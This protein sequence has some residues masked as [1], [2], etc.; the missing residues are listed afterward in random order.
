MRLDDLQESQN[1]VDRRSQSDISG[2]SN[3]DGTPDILDGKDEVTQGSDGEYY[4]GPDGIPDS[5]QGF[6]RPESLDEAA[7]HI[8][9]FQ[10]IKIKTI[11]QII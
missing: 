5:Q 1:V 3:L 9:T 7:C 4:W 8:E 2:D 11:F 10:M 6:S